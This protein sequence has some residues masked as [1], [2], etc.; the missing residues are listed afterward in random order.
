MTKKVDEFR[1]VS[2]DGRQFRVIVWQEYEP[3]RFGRNRTRQS[4]SIQKLETDSGEYVRG[5][6][7][8]RYE[9]CGLGIVVSRV[10][11]SA[12]AGR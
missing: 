11:E 6:P 10:E 1:A 8:G 12:A 2:D 4:P 3:Q 9:I 5:L 7:D